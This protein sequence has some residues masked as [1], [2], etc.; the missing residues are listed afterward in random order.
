MKKPFIDRA[1]IIVSAGK[2]GDGCVSFRRE[3]FVPRGGPDGGRGGE[4]GSVYL[5][6]DNQINTL[7]AYSYRPIRKAE[8]GQPGQGQ[9]KQGRAGRSLV[10]PVPRGTIIRDLQTERVIGDLI[11]PGQ[12]LLLARGGK[13]GKGNASF[14]TS[15]RRAPRISEKG[16]PG[17]EGEYLL[18]L[19][20]IADIGLVGFPNSGKSTLVA[21]ISRAHPRIAAYPFTTLRP[22]LGTVEDDGY[23]K[24]TVADIPG[25]VEGSHQN[26]GL[27]HA[28]LRHI[29]RSRA[30]LMVL[31]MAGVDG[32]YPW[33]DYRQLRRELK[34]YNPKLIEKEFLVAANKMD[35]PPAE[36]NL[37]EFQSRLRCNP[38]RIFPIS[39]REKT[40]LDRLRAA[41]FRIIPE[42]EF[43]ETADE[44]D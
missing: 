35:L 14:A 43:A 18:E 20:L 13:G 17:E 19:R 12:R 33:E 26:V 4:G 2:G 16:Q 32:R 29:E 38:S 42:T 31:D 15:T 36:D 40:G 44:T 23:R 24:I 28:F 21:A 22:C 37:K 1:R 25:L 10:C 6:A 41:F 8:N 11:E 3:K 5:E 9:N 27:G 7:L 34:L 39:A 30:L